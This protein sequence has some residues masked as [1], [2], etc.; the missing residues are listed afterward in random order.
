M[1]FSEKNDVILKEDKHFRIIETDRE[2]NSKEIDS[3]MNP[4]LLDELSINLDNS[5][6]IKEDWFVTLYSVKCKKESEGEIFCD[7]NGRILIL[8]KEEFKN[9]YASKK[10]KGYILNDN[11]FN[12]CYYCD[13]NENINKEI[14]KLGVEI[15]KKFYNNY[16]YK[17]I[18]AVFMFIRSVKL[19]D[20]QMIIFG[21]GNLFI[22]IYNKKDFKLNLEEQKSLKMNKIEKTILSYLAPY[23]MKKRSLYVYAEDLLKTIQQEC[24]E[25]INIF[26][27]C[28]KD[29]CEIND[30]ISARTLIL[31]TDEKIVAINSGFCD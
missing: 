30:L 12:C 16:N 14:Q 7:K 15:T 25:I 28:D 18:D 26:D 5:T 3:Y 6:P 20:N 23:K 27:V 13:D 29:I 10:E 19:I 2:Y 21:G 4:K 11:I 1:F 24:G 9:V 17:F 31:E 8:L 22:K